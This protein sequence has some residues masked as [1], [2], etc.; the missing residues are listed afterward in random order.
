M[1]RRVFPSSSVVGI[2]C[3]LQGTQVQSWLRTKMHFSHMT[4]PKKKKKRNRMNE[5]LKQT[6]KN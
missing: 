5:K 2:P 4:Q 1:L 3:F 6:N